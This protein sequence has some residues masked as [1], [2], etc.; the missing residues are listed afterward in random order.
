MRS[1]YKKYFKYLFLLTLV[2]GSFRVSASIVNGT[3]DQTN[4]NAQVCENAPCTTTSTSPVN[5]GYFTT[6]QASPFNVH[7]TDTELTGFIWGKSFGWAVLNCANTVMNNTPPGGVPGSGCNTTNGEFKVH[8]DNNGNLYGWAWGEDTGWINFNSIV[9]CDADNNGFID[10]VCDGDNATAVVVDFKV[11]INSSGQF[12]GYAW[13]ENHGYIKF[14]CTSGVNYCVQTDWR[15]RN[16][17]P[18]CSD[19]IDNDADGVT[20][21]AD[22]GC[23]N[24][25]VYDPTD[26]LEYG[27]CTYNC[28]PP[29]C[30]INC[31][32]PPCTVNCTPPPCVG[33]ACNPPPPPCTVNC[34]P[35][36]PPCINCTPPPPPCVNCNPPPPPCINCHTPP[37][38]SCT[39]ALCNP[40]LPPPV[41]KAIDT[42]SRILKNKTVNT[43]A[44]VV[45]TGG[46]LVGAVL[47][48]STAVFSSPLTFSEIFLIPIRLW[49][50]LMA[51]LGLKKR[52][53]PWGIVYDSITKQPLDPA[54][55]VLLDL[56]G[57]EVATSITDIDGRY[58]FLVPAG[59]YTL[60]AHKT[61][62]EFPSRKLAGHES[63]EL[64]ADLYESGVITI[65][66]GG[67]ITKNI[68]MDPLNF[69]WNEFAK[70]DQKLMKFYSSRD[71]WITRFTNI[72]FY[73]GFT[74]TTL[75]LIV[76][77]ET[78]NI[79]TF[80][81]YVVL[82]ALKHTILRPRPF[83][84]LTHK[85]SGIPLSF[86][87]IRVYAA[88]INREVTKK[89]ADKTG[90]YY[91]LIPN[92]KYY[93][94]IEQ[95]NP[96]E[97][98]S[99]LYTS[100]PFEVKNGYINKKFEL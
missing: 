49:S 45:T 76:T 1:S 87:I 14:D 56:A 51:A 82:F 23:I 11:T 6:S 99:P 64:Y 67:V 70:R 3:I 52:N 88:D 81:V 71:I 90:K 19:G 63:D 13:S 15:P 46:A 4:H 36:P 30:T 26:T 21:S 95:K 29:P 73:F 98:Y 97:S 48:F 25:G 32:P 77:P 80:S 24:N 72:L 16:T 55:V 20:D 41:R 74:L 34:N 78:Y 47:A 89:V 62:Y 61:N 17:R 75:A 96:D 65:A 50:L 39:G 37:P 27:G 94:K 91:C 22:S 57:N 100:A 93:V 53:R 18:Q 54:Y 33:A 79:V 38:P 58:G 83:G 7:V 35:P 40:N 42:I 10:V 92:G 66:E 86:A 9:N 43:T 44:K 2:C 68:P 8:N 85:G 12:L 28:N 5:F 60:I 69:D 84:R 59:Q 31:T